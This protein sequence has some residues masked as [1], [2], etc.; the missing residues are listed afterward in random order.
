[1]R[2][3]YHEKR[4]RNITFSWYP[5]ALSQNTRN[6]AT[7][8]ATPSRTSIL[9]VTADEISVVRSFKAEG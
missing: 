9:L 3:L 2:G 7:V 6:G 4:T 8:Y 5:L 1:M